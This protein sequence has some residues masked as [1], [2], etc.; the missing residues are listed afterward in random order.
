MNQRGRKSAAAL[1]VVGDRLPGSASALPVPPTLSP[2]ERLVWMA[3]VSAKPGD[4]FGME[5]VPLLVEYCRHVCRGHVVDQQLK[6]FDP[7]WL[8]TDEGLRR[9]QALSAIAYQI[10]G[11]VAR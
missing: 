1:T 10:A 11:M 6:A 7:E 3:T 4:W 2:A 8:K 5:H 9:Y